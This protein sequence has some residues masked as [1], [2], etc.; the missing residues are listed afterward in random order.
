MKTKEQ[1]VVWEEILNRT[2]YKGWDSDRKNVKAVQRLYSYIDNDDKLK[3]EYSTRNIPISVQFR[4]GESQTY[5]SKTAACKALKANFWTL[6][7]HLDNDI[8]VKSGKLKGC[9]FY[10]LPKEDK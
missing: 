2:N 6:R 1:K 10:S 5:K 3:R 7:E 8:P 4:S 9:Y